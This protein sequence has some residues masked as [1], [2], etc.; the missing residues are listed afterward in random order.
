[1]AL[2]GLPNEL[3]TGIAEQLEFESEIEAFARTCKTLYNLLNPFLYKNNVRHGD[4]MVLA[5]G[6]INRS[7]RTVL[8]IL[9][10]GADP[11]ECDRHQLDRLVALAAIRGNTTIMQILRERGVNLARDR[12]WGNPCSK[13]YDADEPGSLLLL[14]AKNGHESLVRFLVDF[15]PRQGDVDYPLSQHGKTALCKAARMGHLHI[16]EFLLDQGAQIDYEDWDG[17]TPLV[18]SL[19]KCDVE[20]P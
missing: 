11:D 3:L 18:M 19:H 13:Y 2:L 15:L 5:W 6:I 4:S 20:I 7:V 16:V 8:M 9:D 12:G 17:Y 14:A 1:M 10:A